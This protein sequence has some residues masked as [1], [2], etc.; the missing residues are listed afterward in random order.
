VKICMV[1]K[2]TPIQGGVSR[3]NFWLAYALAKQGHEVHLVTN[4][5]EVEEEYR[6]IG[7]RLDSFE[8][9]PLAD[10]KEN[11]TIH[12]T[13]DRLNYSY[14]PFANPFLSKVTSK[15]VEV[16][17]SHQCDMILAYYFEPYGV[18][19]FFA[20][21]LT[22][23][24]FGLRHAGSDVGRLMRHPDLNFLYK[25]MIL[26]ADF[27]YCS[28]TT[29]RRFMELGVDHDKLSILSMVS[30]PSDIYHP[31][32]QP[33]DI[34]HHLA[35]ADQELETPTSKMLRGA[36]PGTHYRE[37]LPTIGIYGKVA[38]A[39]GS[40]DLISALGKLKAR[41]FEFNFLALSS[42]KPHML[43]T[44]HDKVVGAGIQSCTTWLPFVPHW[45]VPSFIQRCDAVCFL[46]RDFS[47]PIHRPGVAMEV[48]LCG[49]C[50]VV[51]TEIAEKQSFCD[52]LIDGENALVVDP[53]DIDALAAKIEFVLEDTVRA[54]QIG[55]AGAAM[56][57]E[58]IPNFDEISPRIS[59]HLENT[60]E[61]VK[62]QELDM[63][64]M[65]YQSFINR[66]Y[67]DEIFRKLND[68][69][70]ESA[71][72]FY[73]LTADEKNLLKSLDKTMVNE[74]AVSLKNKAMTKLRGMYPLLSMAMD[75]VEFAQHFAR[76]YSIQSAYPGEEK[77]ALSNKFGHFMEQSVKQGESNKGYLSELARFE[78]VRNSVTLS[79]THEDSFEFINERQDKAPIDIRTRV[80]L[81][82]SVSVFEF[83]WDVDAIANALNSDSLSELDNI[84]EKETTLVI[85]TVPHEF[86]TKILKV[87][88]ATAEIIALV[89]K[90]GTVSQIVDEFE[91]SKQMQNT[92]QKIV[93]LVNFLAG[94]GIV[95][96]SG[97]Q[98]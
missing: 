57:S 8:N 94:N 35:V 68:V 72:A 36:L 93:D 14:I 37:G 29:G 19:A 86:K 65:E 75:D 85:Y 74:Y 49:G 44:L 76:Y 25:E 1:G 70:A 73:N 80:S 59:Q 71:E 97:E 52:A 51:S 82:P 67:T 33:L 7:G 54:K 50:L 5:N 62:L 4:A 98:Q 16:I 27:I 91:T 20:S 61:K 78:R 92:S 10:V 56:L 32:R 31:N 77:S 58:L 84:A 39:K 63:S 11:L 18:A 17:K 96:R 89:K 22:K 26:A 60:F 42:G 6:L 43:K 30:Y 83:E 66:L 34:D 28:K 40:F 41:G 88:G 46:E 2:I 90:G 15:V 87:N 53:K 21:Q 64:V 24:P 79:T 45:D 48:M 12:F 95:R 69:S 23:V 9:T 38:E 55:A 81:N 3:Q 13:R 47:I